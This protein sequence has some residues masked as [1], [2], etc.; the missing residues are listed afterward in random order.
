M[1]IINILKKICSS[2]KIEN[3]TL[4]PVLNCSKMT[5]TANVYVFVYALN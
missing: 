2:A 3:R 1:L 4:F 5:K